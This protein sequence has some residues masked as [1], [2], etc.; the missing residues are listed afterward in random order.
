MS[1]SNERPSAVK[2]DKPYEGFPMF[3][4][5]SGQWAKKVKRV[6]ETG[7]K[8]H[9]FG[10]WRNDRDGV[11]ALERFNREWPY[12]KDGRVPPPIDVGYGLTLRKLVNEFLANKE[13]KL[14]A[15]DLSPRTFIDLHKVCE[16]L[17]DHFGPDRRVDDISPQN[18]G[19]YRDKLAKRFS[20]IVLKSE[21]S[22]VVGIFL[23]AFENRLIDK[24]VSFGQ[25][26]DA[27]SAKAL[28]KS[29]NE[30]GYRLFTRDEILRLLDAADEQ[31]K[32][33]ILLG[34]NC[35]YGN[36]DVAALPVSAIDFEK[37]WA[38]FPRPKTE[39][40]RRCPL[41]P[42]TIDAM[43]VAIAKRP[44]PADPANKELCFFTTTGKPLVRIV[45]K[46]GEGPE[47]AAAVDRLSQL[48]GKL[49][50][51]LHI[52]GRRG[53][54]FYSLRH[55]FQTVGGEA[56]DE[57]AID[58]IMGHVTPGMGSNYRHGISDARLRAVTDCVHDWLF[59]SPTPEEKGE[60]GEA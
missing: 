1:N 6:G 18:F 57:V 21:R 16:R 46:E 53:L 3:A 56:K 47:K 4:H 43:K 24:P 50:R 26:F 19:A 10:S 52:N 9:Y 39:I 45:Q 25:Y 48:F 32:A 22:R 17:I 11:Q 38:T 40:A 27:P 29:R 2:P 7:S 44:K 20:P 14:N 8:L 37:G 60:G 59:T 55:T 5:G 36:G 49:L 31:L 28:R 42:E 58:Q 12:L 30:G 23:F 33:L 34:L 15:G 35:G 54:G 13:S 41:W 51:D